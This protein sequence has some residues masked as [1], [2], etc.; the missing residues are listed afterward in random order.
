MV[1]VPVKNVK[2]ARRGV[3]LME[4]IVVVSIISVMIGVSFP[5]MMS[6]IETLRINGATDSIAAFLNSALNRADRRQQPVE[7]LI[8]RREGK[9]TV[10]GAEPG[11]GRELQL[12]E[13]IVIEKIFPEIPVPATGDEP[14]RRFLLLPG[15]VVPRIAVELVN[16]K[17]VH[18]IIRVDPITGVPM[19]ERR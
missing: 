10:R 9:L 3:T 16:R 15:G 5:S 11:P 19:V 7:V 1:T 14:P 6:G 12:P 8:S 17:G 4:M 2:A 13:G 18:R